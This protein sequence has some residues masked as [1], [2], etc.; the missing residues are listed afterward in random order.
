VLGIGSWSWA[1]EQRLKVTTK[2]TRM[3]FN[4]IRTSAFTFYINND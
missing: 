1:N 2:T 4:D 3:V